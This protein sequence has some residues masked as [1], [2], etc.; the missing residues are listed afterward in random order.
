MQ[1]G[2]AEL[3]TKVKPCGK[4]G[5]WLYSQ[6]VEYGMKNDWVCGESWCLGD[7]PAIGLALNPGCGYFDY[8][9]ASLVDEKGN[10]ISRLQNRTI[11]IYHHIDSRFILE[12]L[13]AKLKINN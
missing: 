6:L 10:Y 3:E 8:A 7:N 9:Q 11:R 1:V 5:Q 2:Y 13:F 4:I 12:D